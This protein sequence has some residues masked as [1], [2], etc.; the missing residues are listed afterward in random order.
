[1]QNEPN[2]NANTSTNQGK[3]INTERNMNGGQHTAKR[4]GPAH[5]KETQ[6]ESIRKRENCY[7]SVRDSNNIRINFEL[8]SI[9]INCTRCSAGAHAS[10]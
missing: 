3:T 7:L 8:W 9:R 1:M 4:N 5:K 6:A 2:E 10:V